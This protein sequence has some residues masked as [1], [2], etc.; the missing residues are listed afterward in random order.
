MYNPAPGSYVSSGYLGG[1][2]STGGHSGIDFAAPRGTPIRAVQAGR[3]LSAGNGG[4]YGNL[5]KVRHSDGSIAYYAHLSSF[6]VR[7]GQNIAR[8]S[9]IGR[10]GNTGN[11]RGRNGGYHLHFEVR[12]GNKPVDPK[13]WLTAQSRSPNAVDYRMAQAAS[14]TERIN[15]SE[16]TTRDSSAL[17]DL[18]EEDAPRPALTTPGGGFLFGGSGGLGEQDQLNDNPLSLEQLIG[19]EARFAERAQMDTLEDLMPPLRVPTNQITITAPPPKRGGN[20][21]ERLLNAIAGQE[22]GNNYRAVNRSSGALGK[23]QIMPGNIASWSKAA[24]GYS[25]TPQQFL[26]DSAIQDRIARH[27]MGQY[28]NKYGAAGAAL[29]WYAGEGALKYSSSTRNRKQGAYPSMNEYVQ[30]VLRR[31]GL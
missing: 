10:V 17:L 31:A 18:L 25:I 22:S 26:R 2:R 4:A 6:N 21:F 16:T 27:R 19:S 11:V 15:T 24:L 13:P 8:G 20:A 29:A 5:I 30:Q 3:I 23:Y 7:A 12:V 28:F 1:F 14:S 9:F